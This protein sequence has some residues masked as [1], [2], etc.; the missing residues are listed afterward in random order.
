MILT[1]EN[2]FSPEADAFF[3]SNSQFHN[4]V[5]TPAFGGCEAKA[6]A[7]LRGEWKDKQSKA[8]LVGSYVDAYFDD[9]LPQF[10]IEHPEIFTQ[11]GTLYSD[12]QKADDIIKI[13]EADEFYMTYIKGDGEQQVIVTGEIGGVQW[14]GKLDTLYRGSA[15]IDGKVIASIREKVW[16]NT[17]KRYMNFIDAY[18]YIDQGAVYREL[19]RQ[20]TGEKLPFFIA[21]IT[22]EEYPDKEIIEIP[23]GELDRALEAIIIK[24]PYV[25]SIK[26]RKFPA[27]HCGV[28]NYC[29]SIKKLESTISYLDL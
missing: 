9:T 24:T 18:G 16:N 13:A 6:M 3:M 10:K 22:K 8:M 23:E 21:A 19:W 12:Y 28:C 1:K 26:E 27:V 2:Y 4:F 5:G 29:R 25:Q 15:I 14:K 17:E 7:M 20:T 11:K